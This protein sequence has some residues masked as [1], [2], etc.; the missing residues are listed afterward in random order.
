MKNADEICV[1]IQ[2]RLSSQRVPRKMIRPFF[3]NQSLFSI[4][5]EKLCWLNDFYSTYASVYEPELDFI[6]KE[7]CVKVFPRSKESSECD[8][9]VR[10]MYEWCYHL[11]YKYVVMFN[12]CLPFLK[13][14]TIEQFIISFQETTSESQFAVFPK[15]DYF[16]DK[17]NRMLNKWPE[18]Q[19][20]FN[21]K[22]VD[23]TYQAAHA[24]YA[25]RIDLLRDKGIWMCK[26]PEECPT[27]Y[28]VG[29]EECLDIDYQWQFDAYRELYK[30]G[31]RPD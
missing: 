2:S 1:V 21:T 23:E 4:A 17:N 8:N 12:P 19:D 13:K 11:P 27:L 16:W 22:A 31:W 10:L 5:C 28:S 29:E 30:S 15:K 26:M 3:G 14:E 25:G 18:G 20:L 7:N 9:N 6:A 24:L